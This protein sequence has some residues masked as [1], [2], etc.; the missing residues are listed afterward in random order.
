MVTVGESL[1]HGLVLDRD[2]EALLWVSAEEKGVCF[3][4][5]LQ[6][7]TVPLPRELSVKRE[8][9][10]S[11]Q[12][13]STVEKSSF[14]QER[15]QL[16]IGRG[17][18]PGYIFKFLIFRSLREEK[19][20][21]KRRRKRDWKAENVVSGGQRGTHKLTKAQ[22]L[23]PQNHS[24]LEEQWKKDQSVEE[25]KAAK[26]VSWQRSC[27][28]VCRSEDHNRGHIKEEVSDF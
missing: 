12:L 20:K 14:T 21:K 11:L 3:P 28:R 13:W 10:C 6:P 8:Q 15:K 22:E 18:L 7:L 19:K 4:S 9:R 16:E 2:N 5:A 24:L 26:R 25:T 23:A 27:G 1:S 17:I